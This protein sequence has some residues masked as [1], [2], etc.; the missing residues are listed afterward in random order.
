[1]SIKNKNFNKG[2][3]LIEVMIAITLFTAIMTIGTGAVLQTNT[4][5]KKAQN[6]RSVMDN[7]NFIIEDMARNLRL[8]ANYQCPISSAD[9]P[10]NQP[11]ITTPVTPGDCAN[12]T[13]IAF[14]SVDGTPVVYSIG[15]LSGAPGAIFK[16]TKGNPFLQITP[17]EVDIDLAKSGFTVV[18]TASSLSGDFIQPRVII[19]LVGTVKYKDLESNFNLETTVSQRFL[20]L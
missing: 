16:A 11:S 6:M 1:M 20:D 5:H 9:L 10:P 14:D 15:S 13:S 8:G 18:G 12:D 3:T 4:V 17:D 19:R 2:F 7:L